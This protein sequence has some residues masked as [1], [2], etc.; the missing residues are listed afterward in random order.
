MTIS[1]R[2]KQLRQERKLT[3]VKVAE[4]LGITQQSYARW[5]NGKVI[6]TSEKL[7]QIAKFY[8]VTTD[9]LLGEQTDESDLS[10]VE[11]L[12][13]MTSEGLT[14]EEKAIFREELI[15]FMKKRKK[16]FEKLED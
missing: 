13:R 9:Y 8:G 2:L 3:Q 10:N 14:D 1:Y 6:P 4:S 16:A 15:E 12:F 5:E 11:L 7:S